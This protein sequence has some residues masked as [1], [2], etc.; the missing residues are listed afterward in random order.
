MEKALRGLLGCLELDDRG[1]FYSMP[2]TRKRVIDGFVRVIG[3]GKGK[4]AGGRT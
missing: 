1:L 2:L 4:G 3:P